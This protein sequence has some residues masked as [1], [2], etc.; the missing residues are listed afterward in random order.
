MQM[1]G[2]RADTAER[3]APVLTILI[4][5]LNEARIIATCVRKAIDCLAW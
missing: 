2:A 5:C 1:V 4:P 3:H